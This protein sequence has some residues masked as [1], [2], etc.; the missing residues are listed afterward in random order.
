MVNI[1]DILIYESGDGGE[2]Q[3]M[4]DDIATV[5]SLTNQVYLAL[6]GGNIE[7]DSTTEI[8]IGDERDDW[9]GNEYVEVPF[10]STFERTLNNVALNSSGLRQLEN[11]AKDDMRYFS[12][13]ADIEV[14]ATIPDVNKLE[15]TISLNQK[16]AQKFAV[17]FVWD[18]LKNELIEDIII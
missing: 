5:S 6:F 17:K 3:L 1:L 2:F 14:S 10:N 13:Y 11:A 18:N 7:Q 16:S 15:I 4:N 9:W 12:D 8:E